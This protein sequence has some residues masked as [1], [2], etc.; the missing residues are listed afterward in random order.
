MQIDGGAAVT[1][2]TTATV[3][4]A[5]T[6][7]NGPVFMKLSADGATAGLWQKYAAT[8]TVTLPA[9][10]GLKTVVGEYE[11]AAGNVV[12]LN[13]TIT[14]SS[15]APTVVVSGAKNG[16]WLSHATTLDFAATASSLSGG[17]ASITLAL[18]GTVSTHT[19]S[20]AS[21]LIPATPNRTHTVTYHATDDLA[22]SGADQ[23][24]I[25]HVDTAGPTTQ[26]EAVAGRAHRPLALKFRIR[27]NLSPTAVRV[28][29]TVR[30][31]GK[32]VKVLSLPAQSTGAWHTV[33]WTPPSKNRYT[34]VVT[35]SDLAGNRQASAKAGVI[36]AR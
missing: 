23:T 9:G 2:S 8:A 16:A 15:D 25:V 5:V 6:D 10:S 11:D 36:T 14:L 29:V 20:Q 32:V 24:I 4:S 19:G 35:A 7:T 31:H 33:K 13:G 21:L 18:D 34:Y 27:D 1:T 12:T 22:L 26:G 3:D 30:L 17:V 28:K